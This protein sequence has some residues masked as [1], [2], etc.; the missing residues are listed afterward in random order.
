MPSLLQW[1]NA[2]IR[3]SIDGAQLLNGRIDISTLQPIDAKAEVSGT[4]DPQH[5]LALLPPAMPLPE[6]L[7]TGGLTGRLEYTGRVTYDA[8]DGVRVPDLT[9]RAADVRVRV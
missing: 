2:S 1:Q 3:V 8:R 6:L 5:V 9:V 4:I 7:R